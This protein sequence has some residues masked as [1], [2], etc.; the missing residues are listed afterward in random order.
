MKKELEEAFGVL[1]ERAKKEGAEGLSDLFHRPEDIYEFEI[2][3]YRNF[4]KQ[5]TVTFNKALAVDDGSGTH[6]R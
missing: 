5:N 3:A 6:R 4:L 2:A 1:C